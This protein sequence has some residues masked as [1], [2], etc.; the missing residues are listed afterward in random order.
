MTQSRPVISISATTNDHK[1]KYL[2]IETRTLHFMKI[3]VKLL[4]NKTTKIMVLD[5]WH[6]LGILNQKIDTLS[7]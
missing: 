1:E 3:T 2:K 7:V 6:T 4:D 5:M